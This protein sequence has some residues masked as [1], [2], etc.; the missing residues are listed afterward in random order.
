MVI[1]QLLLSSNLLYVHILTIHNFHFGLREVN[2]L[3]PVN[4][5]WDTLDLK[6]RVSAVGVVRISLVIS[7]DYWAFQE[8]V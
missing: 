1:L 6:L 4:E 2:Y 8:R 5:R 7:A 3:G